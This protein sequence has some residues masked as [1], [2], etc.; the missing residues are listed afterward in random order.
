MVDIPFG[1][2]ILSGGRRHRA[3]GEYDLFNGCGVASIC[4][5]TVPVSGSE[6]YG[7]GH[8]GTA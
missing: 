7:G 8:F 3:L 5:R 6:G 1:T 4:I 2:R